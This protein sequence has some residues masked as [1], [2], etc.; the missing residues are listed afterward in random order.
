MSI[1]TTCKKNIKVEATTKHFL[2][3]VWVHFVIPQTI[4]LYQ[5]IRFLNTYWSILWSLLDTNHTKSTAFLPQTDVK[6]EVINRMIM[7][8]LCIYNS[9]NSCTWDES[10]TYVQHSYNISLHSSIVHSPFQVGL[11]FLSLGP[12]DVMVPIASTHVESSHFESEVNK[13]TKFIE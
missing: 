2:E 13:S 4:I 6:I 10:L 9:K 12:I 5:D 1:L 11:G 7:H 8:I 3:W